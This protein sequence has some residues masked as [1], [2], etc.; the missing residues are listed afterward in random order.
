MAQR[1]RQRDQEVEQQW[2]L[3]LVLEAVA[4]LGDALRPVLLLQ[5]D[6]LDAGFPAGE[7]TAARRGHP[8]QKSEDEPDL[9]EDRQQNHLNRHEILPSGRNT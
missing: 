4:D 5:C 7:R 9:D 1:Q 3:E 2:D 8:Q 6:V